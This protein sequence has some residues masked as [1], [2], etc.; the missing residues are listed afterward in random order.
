MQEGEE[1]M[2]PEGTTELDPEVLGTLPPS[3]QL[4]FMDKL[5]ERMVSE[6]REQFQQR[7]G[8][9]IDFSTFQMQQ[10]LKASAFRCMS[11]ISLCLLAPLHEAAKIQWRWESCGAGG[12]V[13][14]IM[15]Q[16]SK[17]IADYAFGNTLQTQLFVRTIW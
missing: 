12:R 16:Q 15:L 3:M 10:Y 2:L 6:N 4:E 8:I 11:N 9:P 7:T 13:L 1:L 5:R 14:G 17:V